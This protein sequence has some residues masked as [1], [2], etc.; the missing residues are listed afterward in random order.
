V[1]II[2]KLVWGGLAPSSISKTLKKK[3][4]M[5]VDASGRKVATR[6]RL[7]FSLPLAIATLLVL[8]WHCRYDLR[9]DERPP[10][11][12]KEQAHAKR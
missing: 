12:Q 7:T 5:V 2:L 1:F 9:L 8:L 4:K 3:P 10:D 11:N 6:M